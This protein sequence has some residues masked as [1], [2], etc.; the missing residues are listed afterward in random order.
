[1]IRAVFVQ[2]QNPNVTDNV[3]FG[4]LLTTPGYATIEWIGTYVDTATGL[5]LTNYLYLSDDY[6]LGD[7]TNVAL[8]Y[9]N[10][11]DNFT[12][13]ESPDADIYR[14]AYCQRFSHRHIPACCEANVTNSYSYV[15][16]QFT[17]TTVTTN[18][19]IANGAL[20]NLPLRIQINA[21]QELNL[22]LAAISG[23]NYLS[24]ASTNQFDGNTALRFF[25]PMPTSISALPMDF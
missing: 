1:M 19:T 24:L 15:H 4:N 20:T 13:T 5:T 25:L 8:A 23:N 7:S 2:N 9:D 16:A 22:T 6:V 14:C 18:A 3:Y 11:P 12:F 17:S 21:S 10:L